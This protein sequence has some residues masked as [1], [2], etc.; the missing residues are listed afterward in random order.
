MVKNRRF[1]NESSGFGIR[2][3]QIFLLFCA[4]T[5]GFAMRV[6]LSVA[7]V[8]MA[9]FPE[10]DW[11]ER[12]KSLLLSSFFWGYV[13]TQVPAGPLA[14]RFGG[15]VTIL[16]GLSICSVLTI[17]TPLCARLGGWQLLCAVR[18]V[19][20]ICQGLLFP[21]TH[22]VIS[23]WVP[24][25]E[26]ASLG[27]FTY[28]G[29]QFGTI[30]MLATSG[31]LVSIGDWPCIFY[32]SGAVGCIWSV[33]Y[34]LW[35]ASSPAD[36][37][38]ISAEERELIELGQASERS[39]HAE[40]PS[41]QQTTPWLSFFRSPAVLALVA[42]Q[43]AYAYGFWTLLTQ[44][45]SYMKN[46]LGKD[47]KANAVLSALPYTAM[48]V[49]S[50]LF[51]WLSKLM[52]RKDSISLSFNRKFFNSIG[53]WGPMCLLIALGYVP[54]HMDSLAVVLLTLTVGISSASH[55]GF[56]INHI[57]LSPNFAG[58]LM[59]ICNAIANLMSLAAPLLVGIVV[60]D[61]YDANQWRIVFFVAAGIY[62]AGNGLFLIF[63]RTS[64]QPWNDPPAKQHSNSA[65]ELEAQDGNEK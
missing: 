16:T 13:L 56:L 38:N 17:L 29:N 53:T 46:I 15:K 7:V 41:H 60:T 1:E 58:I 33:V 4:L 24:P 51:A 20:G 11:S 47:I 37:K 10:Y 52:Q 65:S 57:D 45:P 3:V 8:A 14:R 50:F 12:I 30:I 35:G 39:A 27:N 9:E 61:K 63:G 31:L 22:T 55:V 23:A 19:E 44:I 32:A 59:G 18:L 5:V 36:S 28:A 54:R 25:K 42:V 2:H 26:R 21:S 49:L 48:L 43:S 62:L 40:L 34:F 6:N 64:V